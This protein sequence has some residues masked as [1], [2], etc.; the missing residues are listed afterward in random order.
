[1]TTKRTNVLNAASK[2]ILILT[3]ITL[4]N[5]PSF[6]VLFCD[7]IKLKTICSINSINIYSSKN[8]KLNLSCSA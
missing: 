1:M 7:R 5:N 8:F 4:K 3:L 6:W 2:Y